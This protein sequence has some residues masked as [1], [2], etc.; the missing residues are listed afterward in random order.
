MGAIHGRRRLFLMNALVL[1]C[2]TLLRRCHCLQEFHITLFDCHE[3]SFQAKADRYRL[4]LFLNIEF[5]IRWL[6]TLIREQVDLGA[7]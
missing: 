6:A 1:T 7:L 2:I 5:I 4:K 3:A